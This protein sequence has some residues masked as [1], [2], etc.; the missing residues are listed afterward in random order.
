MRSSIR[1]RRLGARAGVGLVLAAL[2]TTSADPALAVS[3]PGPA[4]LDGAVVQVM[5]WNIAGGAMDAGAPA[6][7]AHIAS[8]NVG[9]VGLQ[10]VCE[11]QVDDI[12]ASLEASTGSA[13]SSG[14]GV[15][16]DF[17]WGCLAGYGQALFVRTDLSPR[18][19]TNTPFPRDG[20]GCDNDPEERAYQ[21]VTIRLGTV[22]V[23]VLNTHLG[24]GG[25]AICQM[26]H[27]AQV[28]AQ[29]AYAVVLG[30]LNARPTEPAL[31]SFPTA[32]FVNPHPDTHYT[33]ANDPANC[34]RQPT[35]KI[36][37]VWI[38][39][40]RTG[41]S[42]APVCNRASDHRALVGAVVAP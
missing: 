6:W 29:S 2:L 30:D 13:W 19:W 9:V 11:Y 24:T 33:V 28:G 8:Q 7:A 39:G 15:A 17:A 38:R 32:G 40:L 37:Y 14:F 41:A 20:V 35:I 21:A 27:L 16:Q 36:D 26:P 22:D 23:R 5:T 34:A 4:A 31:R 10:E 12:E 3:E 25:D 1:S 42:P 18:A